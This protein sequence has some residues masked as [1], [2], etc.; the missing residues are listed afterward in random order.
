MDDFG[1]Q[2]AKDIH[3]LRYGWTALDTTGGR[4]G[5]L[6][7]RHPSLMTHAKGA[8][9]SAK[10][11]GGLSFMFARELRVASHLRQSLAS[12]AASVGK[13]RQATLVGEVVARFSLHPQSFWRAATRL[14]DLSHVSIDLYFFPIL[15]VGCWGEIEN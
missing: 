3:D 1:H 14:P 15:M 8:H 6:S 13:P 12:L 9:R 11:A 10:R 2:R 4:L 5:G 7:L